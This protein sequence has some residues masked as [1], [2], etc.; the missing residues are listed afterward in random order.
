MLFQ[1][2]MNAIVLFVSS[3]KKTY[4]ILSYL[5]GT[6]CSAQ[7]P[8]G[9]TKLTLGITRCASASL[10]KELRVHST[11]CVGPVLAPGPSTAEDLSCSR[12]E[13]DARTAAGLSPL[14]AL[15]HAMPLTQPRRLS[16]T[17]ESS[18]RRRRSGTAAASAGAVRGTLAM[19]PLQTIARQC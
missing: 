8:G 13:T 10:S 6:P 2:Y 16:T 14:S 1:W 4:P 12:L 11:A 7:G 19:W 5:H 9:G 15:Q 17:A 3:T 18:S